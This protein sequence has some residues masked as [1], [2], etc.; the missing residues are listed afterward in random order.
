M[1][2]HRVD[3]KLEVNGAYLMGVINSLN[4]NDVRPYREK[5]GLATI[6][7]NHWYPASQIVAFYDDL[8]QAPNGM[9]NLVAI[10]MNVV[11]SIEYPPHVRTMQDALTVAQQMHY[12]GWR[13]GHPG[14]LKVTLLNDRHVRLV[15]DNLPLPADLVYGLCYGMV[16]RFLPENYNITVRQQ[17]DG[18]IYTYDLTW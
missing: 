1:Q 16:K 13:N 18:N 7:P 2:Q 10:G 9:F 17:V 12:A 3:P 14:D 15:F 4:E 11:A 6:D 8:E 5:H